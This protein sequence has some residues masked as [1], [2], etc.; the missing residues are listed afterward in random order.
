MLQMPVL[1]PE[2]RRRGNTLLLGVKPPAD[3]ERYLRR[4]EVTTKLR[5]LGFPI[6]D[7]ALAALAGRGAGPPFSRFGAIPLYRWHEVLK[8]ANAHLVGS[9]SR[10]TTKSSRSNRRSTAPHQE[11]AI[12]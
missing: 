9:G 6:G 12:A 5:E 7:Q 11:T 10:A 3:S 4:T 2:Q 1:T 8:W